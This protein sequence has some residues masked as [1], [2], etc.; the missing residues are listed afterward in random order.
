ML[1]NFK[2]ANIYI[3]KIW[4]QNSSSLFF[5]MGCNT[6]KESVAPVD[7]EEKGEEQTIQEGNEDDNKGTS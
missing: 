5:K 7:G 2:W 4:T 3:L 6:S 1:F